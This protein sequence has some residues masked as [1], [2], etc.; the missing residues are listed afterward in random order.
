MFLIVSF[1]IW[2]K[3]SLTTKPNHIS[4]DSLSIYSNTS[5]YRA[6]AIKIQNLYLVSD[7]R[8]CNCWSLPAAEGKLLATRADAIYKANRAKI[9]NNC[10]DL[11]LMSTHRRLQCSHTQVTHAWPR[12]ALWGT[13][14][15][16]MKAGAV[17]AGDICKWV[18]K[19]W[20]LRM[21][22]FTAATRAVSDLASVAGTLWGPCSCCVSGPFLE[23]PVMC[24]GS[25]N[26]QNSSVTGIPRSQRR[27]AWALRGS[28]GRT[29][30][31]W[32]FTTSQAGLDSFSNAEFESSF[33]WMCFFLCSL[34][35]EASSKIIVILIYL[36]SGRKSKQKPNKNS[37]WKSAQVFENVL[38]E[39]LS[40]V[41]MPI[42]TQWQNL[43]FKVKIFTMYHIPSFRESS[44]TRYLEINVTTQHM[45]QKRFMWF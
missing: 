42:K 19:R 18:E 28:A 21:S 6:F 36:F 39:I 13:E 4:F 41:K 22:K 12:R 30:G 37:T 23:Y 8:V 1:G 24:Y 11:F 20:K 10:K 26:G 16:R 35:F 43:C 14:P 38:D 44:P 31:V 9:L 17:E 33:A 32:P 25:K 45:K 27:A 40:I 7:L 29:D 5:C 2:S 34:P 15:H 3:T